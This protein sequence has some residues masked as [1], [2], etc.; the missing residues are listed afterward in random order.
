MAHGDE[1]VPLVVAFKRAVEI[2]VDR[3]VAGGEAA[4]GIGNAVERGVCTISPGAIRLFMSWPRASYAN[5]QA[6]VAAGLVVSASVTPS[7]WSARS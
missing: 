5:C 2:P 3:G 4:R 7:S 6:V 1:A